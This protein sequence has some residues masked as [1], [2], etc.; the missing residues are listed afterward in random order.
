MDIKDYIL[1]GGGLLIVAV[2][3]HG[4][5]IAWRARRDTLRLD[6]V[7]DLMPG[8]LDDMERLRGEL[9]NGGARVVTGRT[10]VEQESLDLEPA[11]ILLEPAADMDEREPTI[12][13]SAA[14]QPA[15][16]TPVPRDEREPQVRAKVADVLMPGA[17]T[18]G[19]SIAAEPPRRSRRIA[20]RSEP[21][22]AATVT[23]RPPVEE[24]IV[25]NV[26]A[27]RGT[28]LTGDQLFAALRGRGLKFG[29]M[30]IFHRLE[31]GSRNP[32][33]SV[34]NIVEP[35]T[36]DM[37]DMEAFTTPGLCFF[38]QLPGPEN[39]AGAFEDMIASARG[40]AGDLGGELK[41][42]QRSVMTPQTEEHYRQRIADYCRRRLSKRA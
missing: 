5:W 12:D 30:N 2:I 7:P 27:P 25:M 17:S 6:I 29:D 28:A 34:A 16:R 26:L 4:F 21:E 23:E 31:P 13:P 33:Y 37:A 19:A 18:P 39:P 11:P 1:I 20:T 42:E 32:R 36:F 41:D 8:D 3:A 14:S 15:G 35:G 24:L 22:E 9:P 38:M 10:Q 40:V